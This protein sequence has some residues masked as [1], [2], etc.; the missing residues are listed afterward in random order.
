MSDKTYKSGEIIFI[1]DKGDFEVI[2][3]LG[4]KVKIRRV[5]SCIKIIIDKDRI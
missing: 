5:D 1:R 3:D 2:E 4:S